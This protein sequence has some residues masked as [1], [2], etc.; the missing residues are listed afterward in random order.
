VG[1]LVTNAAVLEH[2]TGVG[3]NVVNADAPLEN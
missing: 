3:R 1:L 2:T